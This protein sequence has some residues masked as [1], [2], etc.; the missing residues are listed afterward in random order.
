MSTP[1]DSI[2]LDH[3]PLIDSTHKHNGQSGIQQNSKPIQFTCGSCSAVVEL[4]F[5]TEGQ[6]IKCKQCHHRILYKV[7]KPIPRTYIAR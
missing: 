2:L 3:K 7:R 1:I 4:S 6:Q 5:G